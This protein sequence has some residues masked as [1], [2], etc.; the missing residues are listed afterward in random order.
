MKKI[1]QWILKAAGWK[2]IDEAPSLKKCVICVAPHTSNWDFIIGKLYYSAVG[3]KASFLMKKEWFFFPLGLFFKAIGGVPVDRS[4][5]NSITDQLAERF[6]RLDEFHLAITPEG[7]RKPNADWKKGFYYIAQKAS[8]P[9]QL[10]FIDYTTKE[11]GIAT[12]FYPTGNVDEDLQQIKL[13]YK[14]KK[15]KI[16]ENFLI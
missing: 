5:K 16:P 11:A 1:S 3:R 13:F 4:K 8:V 14:D 10:A 9:I 7:T 6:D 15:G 12:N 2:L